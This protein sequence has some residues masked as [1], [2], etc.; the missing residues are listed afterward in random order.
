VRVATITE[1]KNRLSALLKLVRGG[2]TVVI[3]DRGVPVARLEPA[4]GEIGGRLARLE[5]T[6]AI[7]RA[8]SPPP[9]ELVASPPPAIEGGAGV[10]EALLEERRESR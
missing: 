8:T 9:L 6:G 4:A 5:R 1:T 3:V 2:E 7:R 10:L